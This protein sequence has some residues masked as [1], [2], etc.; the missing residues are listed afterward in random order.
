[1][2]TRIPAGPLILPMLGDR[3]SDTRSPHLVSNA[4]EFLDASCVRR[5]HGRLLRIINVSHPNRD[6]ILIQTLEL[7]LLNGPPYS[8]GRLTALSFTIASRLASSDAKRTVHH[9]VL[10]S[11][12]PDRLATA[13]IEKVEDLMVINQV[14]DRL[15]KAGHDQLRVDAFL[16]RLAGFPP[17]DIA[18]LLSTVE[19]PVTI[20]Q[21]DNWRRREATL[22]SDLAKIA[23]RSNSHPLRRKSL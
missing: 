13:A 3:S 20:E 11:E 2:R 16:L 18:D 9:H 19:R 22:I 21:L 8:E 12:I 4:L 6:D 23:G 5:I 1:M 17:R 7:A 15:T 14:R 10:T